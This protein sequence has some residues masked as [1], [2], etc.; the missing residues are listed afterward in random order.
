MPFLNNLYKTL[1]NL[2]LKNG[3][4]DDVKNEKVHN[5]WQEKKRKRTK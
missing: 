2:I 1:V 5:F 4:I 3:V